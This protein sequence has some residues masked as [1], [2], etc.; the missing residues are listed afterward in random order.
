MTHDHEDE[1]LSPFKAGDRGCLCCLRGV[2][3]NLRIG[4]YTDNGGQVTVTNES[5]DLAIAPCGTVSV[6]FEAS[7]AGQAGQS[8]QPAVFNIH[9]AACQLCLLNSA[10]NPNAS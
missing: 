8:R 5:C 4:S 2:R 10:G 6:G 7:S 9:G 1:H 3:G